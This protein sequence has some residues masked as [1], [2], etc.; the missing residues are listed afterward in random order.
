MVLTQREFQRSLAG[1]NQQSIP[2]NKSNNH[3]SAV[4]VKYGMRLELSSMLH[5]HQ[6]ENGVS[7]L[8]ITSHEYG[9][10]S[11]SIPDMSYDMSRRALEEFAG[12]KSPLNG[13]CSNFSDLQSLLQ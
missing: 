9:R 2:V 1:L 11:E 13:D 8:E 4:M 5:L 12:W 3:I 7:N 10:K 6:W